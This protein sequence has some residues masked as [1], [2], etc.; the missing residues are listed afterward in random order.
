MLN[1][2]ITE[3]ASR[4][5]VGTDEE[6]ILVCSSLKMAHRVVADARLLESSSMRQ[7]LLRRMLNAVEES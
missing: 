1:Y 2:R 5:V 6:A 7:V 3:V 4:V